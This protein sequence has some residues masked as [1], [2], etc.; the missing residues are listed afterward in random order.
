MSREE[1]EAILEADGC[2]IGDPDRTRWVNEFDSAR[3][4]QV[5]PVGRLTWRT[6]RRRD[7]VVLED[8][9][10]NDRTSQRHLKRALKKP[11]DS[12]GENKLSCPRQR[13]TSAC[14]EGS[15]EANERAATG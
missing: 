8:L 12:R 2:C 1:A 6:T 9:Y 3:S 7:G 4:M 13:R 10:V 14:G 5:P 15:I 11:E